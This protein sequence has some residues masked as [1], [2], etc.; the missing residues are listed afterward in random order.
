MTLPEFLKQRRL[1]FEKEYMDSQSLAFLREGHKLIG[2]VIVANY[3][4][5][6]PD[7]VSKIVILEGMLLGFIEN[8]FNFRLL[9]EAQRSVS[10]AVKEG[11]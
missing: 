4:D 7:A 3:D 6:T 5:V 9:E 8:C 11:Q 10:Q 2:K 1:A